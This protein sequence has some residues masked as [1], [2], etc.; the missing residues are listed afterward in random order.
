MAP[1]IADTFAIVE[2][3]PNNRRKHDEKELEE[4]NAA[5][6]ADANDTWPSKTLGYAT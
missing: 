2:A 6:C 3:E 4:A 5:A 1:H